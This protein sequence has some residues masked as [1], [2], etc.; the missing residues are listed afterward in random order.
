MPILWVPTTTATFGGGIGDSRTIRIMSAPDW[1]FSETKAALLAMSVESAELEEVLGGSVTGAVAGWLAS[2]YAQTVREQ[3]AVLEGEERLKLLRT[4][5][6]DWALLRKG[7]QTAERLEIERERLM[8]ERERLLY[9]KQDS[10]GKF[11][12]KTTV[13]LEAL[14]TYVEHHPKAKAAFDALLEQV[15][16]PWDT[17]EE[18]RE[19]KDSPKGSDPTESD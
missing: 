13:G 9:V 11:K 15:R 10:M 4:F 1:S 7:D 17:S 6:Q 12:R 14:M 18:I 16:H 2:R 8:V 3:L 5:A 19:W